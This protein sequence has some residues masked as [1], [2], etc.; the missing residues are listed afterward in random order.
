[1]RAMKP[2]SAKT[3]MPFDATEFPHAV[4]AGWQISDDAESAVRT[5]FHPGIFEMHLVVR[6]R[7]SYQIQ[8]SD[9]TLSAGDLLLIPPETPHGTGVDPLGRCERYWL[10]IREPRPGRPLPGLTEA[11]SAEILR[12]LRRTPTRP[13]RGGP[14]FVTLFEKIRVAYANE[15]D[16]LRTANLHNL[17]LRALLDFLALMEPAAADAG[18]SGI[19]RAIRLIEESSASVTPAEMARV[20]GMS[21][22]TLKLRFKKETGLPPVEYATRRR[23]ETARRLLHATPQ[24]VTEVAHEL[25]F[26]SSQ[27]FATVF[28]RYTGMTPQEFRDGPAGNRH[29][30]PVSGAGATFDPLIPLHR[31]K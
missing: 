5:H 20:A 12:R 11:A 10:Q 2:R 17:L 30:K 15:G 19:A 27:H 7:L 8:G 13:F 23:I 4:M 31:E 21:E 16:P 14:A 24:S 9:H 28:R 18:T 1:M 6:G 3:L 22:S 25:G 26:S 29:G